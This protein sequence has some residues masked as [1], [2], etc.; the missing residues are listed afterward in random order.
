MLNEKYN[1]YKGLI[2]EH[3]L[4]FIPEIDSKSIV[5]YESIKYSLTSGGK[6]IRPVLLLAA[7]EFGKGDPHQALTYATAIEYIHSY[8]LIHDDLPAM[9]NDDLRRGKATNHKV[10]GEDIAILA[11]DGLLTT[12]LEAM[13]RDMF[14]YFDDMEKLKS[15]ARAMYEIVKGSGCKGMIAGQVAD[16][17]SQAK[18]CSLELLDYIHINKTGALITAALRAGAHLSKASETAIADLTIYGENLGLAFQI[19]DDILNVDGN[20]TEMGKKKGSDEI[21]EKCTYVKL[22]GLEK[23]KEK[24]NELVENCRNAIYDYGEESEFLIQLAEELAVRTK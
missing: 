3:I 19:R 4:D 6:R 8:S 7:C 13:N 16:M 9:D 14:L 11:G 5:L 21:A 10:F 2:D 22:Y 12:A 24:I 18:I 20:E 15:R 23:S 1:E 17:E